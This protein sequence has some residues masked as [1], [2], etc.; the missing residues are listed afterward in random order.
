MARITARAA[1]MQMIYEHLA[2]GEGGE[3]TLQMVYDELRKDGVPG[4]DEIRPTEP[5]E[6]DRAYIS[7]ILDGVLSHVTELDEKI[8]AASVNWSL[9]RIAK[10]DL[11]ILRLATYEIL[12]EDDVPGSVAINEAVDLANRYSEPSS[13]RFING[14]LGAYSRSVSAAKEET[15]DGADTGD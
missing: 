4:V 12:Y 8:S 10:V 1:V 11:T 9:E 3:E 15:A 5:G 7:R 14:V 13:G 2:G 6:A